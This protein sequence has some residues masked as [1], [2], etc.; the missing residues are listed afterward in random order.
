MKTA[1]RLAL[2][3]VIGV[4]ALCA[5]LAA[6]AQPSA[7]TPLA[8]RTSDSG[9]V[10]VVVTPKTIEP[11]AT[12]WEFEVVM[13]THT[14]PLDQ[15]LVHAAVLVD[16]GGRQHAP[17]AWQGDPPGGHH[18]KGI[19]RFARSV[20]GSKIIELQISGVGEPGK[21]VFRWQIN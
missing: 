2:S 19:L 14:K 13:D 10:R 4:T 18:R 7:A 6:V 9:G 5:A 17:L 21:R 20:Q 15:D 11:G 1:N 12:V 16:D 8:S 3:I